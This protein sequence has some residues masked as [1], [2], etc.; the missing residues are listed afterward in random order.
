MKVKLV[1]H[2]IVK[3]DNEAVVK[4]NTGLIFTVE[5]EKGNC[6]ICSNN[7]IIGLWIPKEFCEVVKQ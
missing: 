4:F 2:L 1:K 5:E 7:D 3:F 6:W